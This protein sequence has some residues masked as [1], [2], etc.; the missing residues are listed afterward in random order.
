MEQQPANLEQVLERIGHAEA[1]AGK[2]SLRAILREIEHRSFGSLLLLA[3]LITFSPVIGDIPG[4]SALMG[5]FVLLTVGQMLFHRKHFW[6]PRRMLDLS[7]RQDAL[8][9]LLERLHP[10]ACFTDRL[11]Q[12]RL[13]PLVQ[14]PGGYMIAVICALIALAMPVL[15]LVPFSGYST[16]FVLSLFGLSLIGRDGLL[17][18]IAII[19]TSL[20]VGLVVYGLL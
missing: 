12:P 8:C 10:T 2:V 18:L 7:V 17:A 15:E 5:I 4:M 16:G 3:G 13:K 6:L 11:L 14:G 9:K 20:C 19:L 1:R